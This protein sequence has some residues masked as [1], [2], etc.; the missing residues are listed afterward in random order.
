MLF[1]LLASTN[2]FLQF[3]FIT[4]YRVTATS[5]VISAHFDDGETI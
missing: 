4:H 2:M 3:H 5:F 1:T